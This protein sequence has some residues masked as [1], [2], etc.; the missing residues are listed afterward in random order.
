MVNSLQAKT[1][2]AFLLMQNNKDPY[3]IVSTCFH[4]RIKGLPWLG[5]TNPDVDALIDKAG[6]E[7]NDTQ[8]VDAYKQLGKQ[9]VDDAPWVFLYQQDDIYGVRD[10]VQNW[11]PV[12]DQ[13]IYINGVTVHA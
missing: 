5:Y 2:D 9:L 6:Q 7:T 10:Q 1:S 13:I 3:I 8:R 12:G 11:K 4:S